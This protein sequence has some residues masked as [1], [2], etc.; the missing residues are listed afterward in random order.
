MGSA[1]VSE[2]IEAPASE[3]WNLVRWDNESALIDSG[4]FARVVY[5]ERRPIAGATRALHP[6][7]GAPV[8]ERLTSVD[9]ARLSYV[10]SVIDPG[11]MPLQ[12][13][14]GQACV[15]P[16]GERACRLTV[17]CTFT[18]RGISD[19]EWVAIYHAIQQRLIAYLRERTSRPAA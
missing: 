15:E 4:A 5:E 16:E 2:R 6:A 3:V 19:E 10:Y 7:D 1:R 14:V 13:Y 8:R 18:P 17:S 11:P 9:A 12:E